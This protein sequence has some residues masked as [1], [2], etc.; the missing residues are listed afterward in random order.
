MKRSRFFSLCLGLLSAASASADLI[1]N[2]SGTSDSAVVNFMATG[3]VTVTSVTPGFEPDGFGRAPISGSWD[4]IFDNNIGDIFAAGAPSQL[5]VPFSTSIFYRHDGLQFGE[6]NTVD[7]TSTMTPGGDDFE[8]DPTV[9][10]S[11]P[12]LVSGDVI[13]WSG[14]GTFTLTGGAT[15]DSYFIPGSTGSTEIDGGN[16]VV[17]VAAIPEPS[18]FLF[19]SIAACSLIWSRRRKI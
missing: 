13:S 4:S 10:I 19:S 1:I 11:Y 12:A 17:N 9:S 6:F 3:A 18:G 5:N 2:L 14:S 8:P 7:M 16:F 15:Y